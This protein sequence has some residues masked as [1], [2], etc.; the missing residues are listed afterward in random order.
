MTVRELYREFVVAKRLREDRHDR[1]V[2][3]AYNIASLTRGTKG[4]PPLEKLLSKRTRREQQSAV[5][6]VAMWQVIAT[7]FGGKFRPKQPTGGTG[8]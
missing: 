2:T 1:D 6:Q 7:R 8:G 5:E 4:L 3:L